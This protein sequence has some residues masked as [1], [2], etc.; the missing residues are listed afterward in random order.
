MCQGSAADIMKLAMIQVHDALYTSEAYLTRQRPKQGNDDDNGNDNDNDKDKDKGKGED[1]KTKTKGQHETTAELL[2]PVSA[3]HTTESVVHGVRDVRPPFSF[4]P[5]VEA[6]AF[7]RKIN[8][9]M[10]LQIHDEL[11]FEVQEEHVAEAKFLITSCMER[12]CPSCTIPLIVSVQ[13]GKS[14]GSMREVT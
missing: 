1:K 2:H 5:G 10:V 11:L 9:R 6:N 3:L 7:T 8:A 14:W 4:L 12:A 13:V